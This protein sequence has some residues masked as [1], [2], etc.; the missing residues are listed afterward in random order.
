MKAGDLVAM[1]S[2]T[3]PG[4]VYDTILGLVLSET[5]DVCGPMGNGR[6][7]RVLWQD[8]DYVYWERT[9]SLEVINECR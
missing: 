2:S 4:V 7:V 3:R 9:T 8:D 1:K 5:P 6:R